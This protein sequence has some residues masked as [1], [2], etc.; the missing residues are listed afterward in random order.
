[1][2]DLKRAAGEARVRGYVI[3]RFTPAFSRLCGILAELAQ[4]GEG[5]L[6]GA[7]RGLLAELGFAGYF[8][9]HPTCRERVDVTVLDGS[10]A[11]AADLSVHPR[12]EMAAVE[13]SE[14]ATRLTLATRLT[15]AAHRVSRQIEG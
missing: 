13:L 15:R 9:N 11:M 5:R 10:G 12:R 1:M 8:A 4:E 14:A 3:E 7:V 6:E 2:A